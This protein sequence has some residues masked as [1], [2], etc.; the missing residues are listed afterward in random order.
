MEEFG[1]RGLC[2]ELIKD[3]SKSVGDTNIIKLSIDIQLPEKVS[4]SPSQLTES[5]RD[6]SLYLSR[7][8]IN[9]AIRIE[10]TKRNEYTSLV[11]ALVQITG[12]SS[13]I[14]NGKRMTKEKVED[15][16]KNLPYFIQ[17]KAN[18]DWLS[19]KFEVEL[20]TDSQHKRENKLPFEKKKILLAEDNEINA[21][22]FTSFLEEWGCIVTVAVNGSEA[23]TL[24]HDSVFEVILMDIYM[25]LLN[26]NLAT[27][28]I[29]EF[30]TTI[31]II[32]LTAS[33]LEQDIRDAMKAGASDY[34][35]KPVSSKD[36]L[37][38]LSNYL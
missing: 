12:Y 29:R 7:L 10:I 33:T 35:F 26:G 37:R 25:P 14:R 24:A 15:Q 21:M 28:K 18:E 20:F 30:N 19:F 3:L 34:L 13:I 1:L 6:I 9:G 8:L 4:G 2:N 32:A 22:V 31:P 5:I 16:F 17:Y 11:T 23:V 27:E 38:I 36:L